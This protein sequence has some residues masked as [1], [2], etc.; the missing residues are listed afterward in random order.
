VQ[1][2]SHKSMNHAFN[3][4]LNYEKL[5][6][7]GDSILD[8]IVNSNLVNYTLLGKFNEQE[9]KEAFEREYYDEDEF[10]PFDAHQAKSLLTKNWF[11]AKFIC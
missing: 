9:R 8:Y 1:A 2:L 5:E 6:V 4:D 3:Y 10:Q 7:L 11:L